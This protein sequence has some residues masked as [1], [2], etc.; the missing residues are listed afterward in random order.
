MASELASLTQIIDIGIVINNAGMANDV[1]PFLKISPTAT[2]NALEINFY[3]PYFI[4]RVLVQ[5][6]RDRNHRSAI[7]NFSSITG[8]FISHLVGAYPAS[9][10]ILDIYTRTLA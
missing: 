9:K 6:M 2:L 1:S 7:I 10:Q 5:K 8:R 4:N 3:A